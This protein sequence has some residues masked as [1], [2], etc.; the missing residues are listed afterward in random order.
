MR[1]KLIRISEYRETYFSK[2]SAPADS[3]VKRWI[4]NKSILGVK[5]GSNYFIDA[6]KL[7]LTGNPLVDNVITA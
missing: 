1:K 3:T 7:N 5:I 4:N 2:S 6:N